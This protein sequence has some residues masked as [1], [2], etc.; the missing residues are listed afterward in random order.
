MKERVNEGKRYGNYH[1]TITSEIERVNSKRKKI[2]AKEKKKQ[3][4]VQKQVIEEVKA[5]VEE[6]RIEKKEKK[7]KE[8]IAAIKPTVILKVGDRVRMKDG[9]SIGTIEKIEKN[10]VSVNYGLFMSK[11]NLDELEYVQPL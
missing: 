9:K 11:V 3:E 6:I 4:V 10:K 7:I 5:K 1:V 2:S 8:K